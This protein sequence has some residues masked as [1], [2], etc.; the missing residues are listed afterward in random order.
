MIPVDIPDPTHC[1]REAAR[2]LQRGSDADADNSWVA[3]CAATASAWS[4]LGVLVATIE[5]QQ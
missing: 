4:A 1:A 2:W 3:A 5:G